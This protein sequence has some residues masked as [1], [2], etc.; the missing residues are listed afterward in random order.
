MSAPL[1]QLIVGL[2]RPLG[3]DL[4]SGNDNKKKFALNVRNP[5]DFRGDLAAMVGAARLGERRMKRL[6]DEFGGPTVERAV[7]AI[8]DAAEQQTRAVIATW[9]DGVFYGEAFLDDDGSGGRENIRTHFSRDV[10]RSAITRLIAFAHA[11]A[12]SSGAGSRAR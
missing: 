7:D 8:L 9:K 3:I 10:A 11:G 5:R 12:N 2:A 1:F 4:F 6:F